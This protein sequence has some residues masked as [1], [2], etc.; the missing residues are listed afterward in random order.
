MQWHSQQRLRTSNK[1]SEAG[2][3]LFILTLQTDRQIYL[4]KIIF[5]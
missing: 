2:I 3:G 1:K 4:N 5:N